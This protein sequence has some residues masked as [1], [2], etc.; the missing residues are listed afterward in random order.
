MW[1][2]GQGKDGHDRIHFAESHDGL[3]WEKRGVVLEDKDAN[4][5]NDP[6]VVRVGNEWWMYYTRAATDILDE[7][8]LAVS[9]DGVV[10]E[11]RGI[12]LHPGA[13]G[14]W[15][16]LLVGRP[17]VLKESGRF[18]I[19]YDG[20]ADLPPDAPATGVPKSPTSRR[21]VGYA[22]SAVGNLPVQAGLPAAL[23]AADA[24]K[25]PDR[26]PNL[27]FILA[28]DLGWKDR[29]IATVPAKR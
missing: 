5:V 18:K 15:D 4:H 19:W 7:I 8:A 12:V 13:P 16:A 1:Y 9:H 3:T 24:P 25:T 28:D 21:S 23:L 11:K 20:R 6:S 10:W 2:G 26:K 22:E 29:S 14:T 17:S 27:I